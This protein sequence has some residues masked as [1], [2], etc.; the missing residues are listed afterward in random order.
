VRRGK[1]SSSL[2]LP[3]PLALLPGRA[4][5]GFAEPVKLANATACNAIQQQQQQQQNG[6]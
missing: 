4:V 5:P 3:P 1:P 6:G 2:S